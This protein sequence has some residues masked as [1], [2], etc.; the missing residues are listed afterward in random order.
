MSGR[1]ARKSRQR[2]A[3]QSDGLSESEIRAIVRI[4]VEELFRRMLPASQKAAPQ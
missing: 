3:T 4:C 2:K 1:A